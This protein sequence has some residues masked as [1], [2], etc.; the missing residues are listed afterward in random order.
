MPRGV[1]GRISDHVPGMPVGTVDQ[2]ETLF[3]TIMSFGIR[4]GYGFASILR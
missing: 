4:L 3:D 1:G 2:A